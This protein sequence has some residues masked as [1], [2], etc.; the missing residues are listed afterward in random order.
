MWTRN[1]YVHFSFNRARL[2]ALL[3][4]SLSWGICRYKYVLHRTDRYTFISTL[5]VF[6][7]LFITTTL[8]IFFPFMRS[9]SFFFSIRLCRIL[10]F[11]IKYRFFIFSTALAVLC[12]RLLLVVT[13]MHKHANCVALSLRV[14]EKNNNNATNVFFFLILVNAMALYQRKNKYRNLLH[15]KQ[16][17]KNK[18]WLQASTRC[19]FHCTSIFTGIFVYKCTFHYGFFKINRKYIFLFVSFRT[20]YMFSFEILV[21][22]AFGKL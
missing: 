4:L 15:T 8:R 6:K 19:V 11:T 16:E 7:F 20:Y 22:L 21:E 1:F 12:Q 13:L 10:R 5:F 17:M 2:S 3:S 14:D 18:K 9:S